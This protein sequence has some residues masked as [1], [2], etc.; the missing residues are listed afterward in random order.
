[1]ETKQP[2]AIARLRADVAK[3]RRE[4]H[5]VSVETATE[6]LRAL[7]GE[8]L[9]PDQA[10][11]ATSLGDTPCVACQLLSPEPD[12]E[13]LARVPYWPDEGFSNSGGGA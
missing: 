8:R 11:Y 5:V 7:C 9:R 10:E 3:G 1:M 2:V 12:H 6:R 4:V 13:T